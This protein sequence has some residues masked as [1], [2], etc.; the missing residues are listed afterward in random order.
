MFSDLFLTALVSLNV[1]AVG[2]LV[3][4]HGFTAA[5]FHL[6]FFISFLFKLRILFFLHYG[7]VS[8]E[9]YSLWL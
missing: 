6:V 4:N 7:V 2:F 3:I 1:Y 9:Y 5:I 8:A